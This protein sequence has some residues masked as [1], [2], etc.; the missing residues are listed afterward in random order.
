MATFT[1][2]LEFELAGR[3]GFSVRR[4]GFPTREEAMEAMHTDI[5]KFS[6]YAFGESDCSAFDFTEGD[7]RLVVAMS[8]IS[9]L[10]GYVEEI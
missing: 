1:P 2:I 6:R 8:K 9:A 10:H 4:G 7:Q 3:P 5:D